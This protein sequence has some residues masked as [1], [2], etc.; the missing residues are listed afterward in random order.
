MYDLICDAI[1]CSVLSSDT[2]RII[3]INRNSK[4]E[5][6]RKYGYQRNLTQISI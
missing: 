5:K 1:T 6:N 2:T 3:T 4:P